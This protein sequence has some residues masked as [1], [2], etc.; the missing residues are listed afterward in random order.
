MMRSVI[1]SYAQPPR[2]YHSFAHVQ[3]VLRHF[4][5]V[6]TWQHPREVY[7]AV[8]FHDAIYFAGKSD[9]E[10][11]SADL[12]VQAIETFIPKAN[13]DTA[14]VRNLI[15]L[16]AKHGKLKREG[17]TEDT[18]HFLDCDMAI[19]GAPAEQFDA[20]DAAIAEEYREV[21]KI[22]YRFNRKRFLKHLLDTERI[23]LSDL[24]HSRL[25]AAARANLRRVLGRA[26]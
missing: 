17:L 4:D 23:F 5:S 12:A 22:L 13:V 1:A 15:E 18:R 20:Y 6:P 10:A 2:A 26:D 8:L 25:D 11:R 21:P 24:F 3:E 9:N 7:L 16:T 19:L 14:L